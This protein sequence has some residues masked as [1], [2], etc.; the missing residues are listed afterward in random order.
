MSRTSFVLILVGCSLLPAATV[1]A[2][3]G[4]P[5]QFRKDESD[6]ERERTQRWR[7]GI[8]VAAGRG[9]C[10]GIYGTFSVPVDWPEQDVKVVEE[11][12]S[13]IVSRT[14]YRNLEQRVR[15]MI[16]YIASLD[17]GEEADVTL[18]FEIT[19]RIQPV[20]ADTTIYQIP[21]KTPRTLRHCLGNSPLISCRSSRIRAK[22]RE[23]TADKETD[24]EKVEAIYDWVKEN[25]EHT[26]APLKG[27]VETLENKAGNHEDLANLFIAL[28][29]VSDVPARI[30]WVPRYSYAEF[31]LEVKEETEEGE[32]EEGNE[33]EE[34]G[35]WF[36][37][38]FKEKTEFGTVSQPYMILQKGENI[39]VPE[40]KEHKRFVPEFLKA[41][42]GR[43]TVT[44]VRDVLGIK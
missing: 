31:Y 44:T 28:C 38:E 10:R 18:T 27:A 34:N 39:E 26:N 41:K 29:R 5:L 30:V 19:R 40:S 33:E 37:C 7:A 35:R 23:L 14:R 32:N 43:P 22:A 1:S 13:D 3:F 8:R 6:V 4:A 20:P 16:F 25:I 21:E 9:P 11:N 36:S 2:Q 15:Q 42:S 12:I 24:W 17:A